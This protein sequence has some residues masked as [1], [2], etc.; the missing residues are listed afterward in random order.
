M[1]KGNQ[2]ISKKNNGI[3]ED[4]RRAKRKRIRSEKE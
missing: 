4:K 3:K 2:N 1:P